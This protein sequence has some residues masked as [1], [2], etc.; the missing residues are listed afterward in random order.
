MRAFND[1]HYEELTI[2]V[3]DLRVCVVDGRLDELCSHY[4]LRSI[5]EHLRF[6][7]MGAKLLVFV[8]KL[9]PTNN[10]QHLLK[11]NHHG[12]LDPFYA[13]ESFSFRTDIEL[14]SSTVNLPPLLPLILI[15]TRTLLHL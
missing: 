15:R 11:L 14:L 10:C 5:S 7:H 12:A 8:K 9:A 2:V 1:R 13:A 3:A 6:N 4:K